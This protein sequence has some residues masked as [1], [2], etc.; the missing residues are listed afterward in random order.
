MNTKLIDGVFVIRKKSN[1]EYNIPTRMSG[2]EF[3]AWKERNKVEINK[4]LKK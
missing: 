4:F 2:Q 3:E 1:V